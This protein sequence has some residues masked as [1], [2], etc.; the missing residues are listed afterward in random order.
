M[1]YKYIESNGVL[2]ENPFAHTQTALHL[3][4]NNS[5]YESLIRVT[6]VSL[7]NNRCIRLILICFHFH[8]NKQY[9]IY[10][11]DVFITSSMF[12]QLRRNVFNTF[13]DRGFSLASS[14]QW[15]F[16][17]SIHNN[18]MYEFIIVDYYASIRFNRVD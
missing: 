7:S 10:S 2:F 11:M 14:F 8:S 5:T 17:F 4:R 6:R 16:M 1:Y 13:I 3:G 15:S 9:A 12:S 18:Y